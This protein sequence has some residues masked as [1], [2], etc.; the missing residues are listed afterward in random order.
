MSRGREYTRTQAKRKKQE[1]RKVFRD[2]EWKPS[3]KSIGIHANTPKRCSCE[4]CVNPRTRNCLTIQE[5]K[6]QEV[7]V[8]LISE[9]K[10]YIELE[11]MEQNEA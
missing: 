5:L 10:I 3:D 11:Q 7:P 6:Q 8:E 9:D 4:F 2:N 1:A